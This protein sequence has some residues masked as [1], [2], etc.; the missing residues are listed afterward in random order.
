M[1]QPLIQC[2]THDVIVSKIGEGVSEPLQIVDGDRDDLTPE[3]IATGSPR[4]APQRLQPTRHDSVSCDP[5]HCAPDYAPAASDKATYVEEYA[6]ANDG[7]HL[8]ARS[9]IGEW[10]E[11]PQGGPLLRSFLEQSG[12][13]ASALAPARGLPLQQLVPM[14]QGRLQQ[15]VVDDLVRAAN[16]GQ[17]PETPEDQAGPLETIVPSRFAGRTVLVTGAASGIGRAT[18][19]RI[20]REGGRV[21][22][23]DITAAPLDEFTLSRTDADVLAVVG[24]VRDE[25]DVRA[26]IEAATADGHAVDGLANVAGVMDD[27]SPAHE[28]PDDLWD[29]VMGINVTGPFRLMR[30]VLP[31]MLDAGRGA[32]VNVASEAGIRGN[33]AGAAYTTSKHAVVGLT[34]SAAVMYGSEGIRTNAVAPGGVATGMPI[35]DALSEF[36]M[37]RLRPFQALMPGVATAEQLAAAITF[38]LSDDAVN[39]N[40]V[41]L[42]SDGGWSVQ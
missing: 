21:V 39:I 23:F 35:P 6:V 16:G 26:V 1:S 37:A 25:D 42:P 34:R 18:A 32:I 33:A 15:S 36:G 17:M 12:Q 40:G 4:A 19:S 41:V 5:H 13:D 30:A 20:A 31:S 28:T 29:R 3:L 8:T 27:F 14:S 38:L 24:D 22:A 7:D 2:P 9:T 10:L 11:H